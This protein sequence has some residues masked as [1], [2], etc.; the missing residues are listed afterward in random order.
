MGSIHPAS[1]I[2]FV[3]GKHI[4]YNQSVFYLIKKSVSGTVQNGSLLREFLFGHSVANHFSNAPCPDSFK[5]QA[6]ILNSYFF[7]YEVPVLNKPLVKF[8]IE[9]ILVY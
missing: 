3:K 4:T 7:L 6:D 2:L 5:P 9:V 1:L 8:Y